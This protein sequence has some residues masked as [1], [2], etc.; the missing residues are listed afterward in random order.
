MQKPVH[1]IWRAIEKRYGLNTASG[2]VELVQPFEAIAASDSKNVAHLFQQ[3]KAAREQANRNSTEA[4]K[5]GL[6]SQQ[7]MLIKI[8]A[9]LPGHLWGS[10][11][12]F[13]PEEF[14]LDKVESKLCAIFGNKSKAK[15]KVLGNGASVNRVDAKPAK[16]SKTTGSTLGKRKTNSQPDMHQNLGVMSC[17]YCAGVHND[18]SGGPHIK[19]QYGT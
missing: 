5:V 9:V 13:T 18:I 3:L 8:L 16:P 4:L 15:I 1:E 14:R 7:M 12:V 11:I 19:N 2:V 6:I 17:Y 10:A